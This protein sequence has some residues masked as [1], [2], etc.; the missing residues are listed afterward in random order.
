MIRSGAGGWLKIYRS[1]AGHRLWLREP[2][3]IGQA[4]VDLL[5][6]ANYQDSTEI[7]GNRLVAIKRGQ[8]LTS[9]ESLWTRWRRDRKTVRA[10]LLVFERDG[11]LGRESVYGPD[12]GYTLLTLRNYETYQAQAGED[13]DRDTASDLVR[14]TDGA[15]GRAMDRALDCALP[16]FQEEVEENNQERQERKNGHVPVSRFRE[17]DLG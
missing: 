13:L 14:A 16:H 11:M 2:F 5:M 7:R 15:S 3:T 10:W 9:I 17:V 8:V 12:G 4:W 6:L 1:M